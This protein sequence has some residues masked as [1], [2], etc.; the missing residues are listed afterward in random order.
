MKIK[1]LFLFFLLLYLAVIVKLFFAQVVSRNI[2]DLDLYLKTIQIT[3]E[4]GRIFDI[5]DNP[6][7]LNQNSYLL[8]LLP[9]KI[10]DKDYLAHLLSQKINI[11][12]ASLAADINENLF[13][14]AIKSGIGEKTKNEIEKLHLD[15]VGFNY[16]LKRY[17]PEASL[18]AHLVGF[19]GK[20]NQ[21]ADVGYFGLEG[22]YDKDLKGLPGFL[23]TERDVIGNPIFIGTQN[24]VEADNGR[25]LI[26]TLDKSV[27]EIA[28]NEL[29]DG[30][31]KYK[32][33]QGCV[34]VA[35]PNTMAITALTCLPDYD[36]DQYYKFTENY[37]E[38]PAI[39]SAY[40]PGS[41]FKPLIMSA[42]INEKKVTPIDTMT[43]AGPVKI[44][45]Y[46]IQTWDNTYEG[47]ISM[48][49]ILEKSS[50]V[51]M[52]YIGSKLGN[53]LLYKYLIKYGFNDYT[54]IDLQGETAGFIKPKSG[55]YPID[56]ATATFGQGIAVT[57]IQ[58]ITAFSSLINGGRLMRPYVVSKIISPG[59]E[60]VIKPKVIRQTISPLTSNIIKKMLVDT[61]EHGE[62][63]WQRPAGY[64]IGGK[65]GTA[66]IPIKGYYDPSKTIASFIGFAPADKPKFIVLVMLREPQTSIWGSETA[67]PMFF[68]IAKQLIVYYGIP[69]SQ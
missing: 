28:K 42:A 22:Y 8:Y 59:K 24:R 56:Y 26:L 23:E 37:F 52:V 65:T 5:N 50:N 66:Q 49:R 14:Q 19:V 25:D 61:V 3:P 20:D 16:Q 39:S 40:E 21:G 2:K 41:I 36:L 57:P 30:I 10:S 68:D 33:K 67:A 17:Y 32:A 18:S 15:S 35:D 53:D 13:Y 64:A 29:Q 44:G 27:Q 60:N 34:I 51:G 47:T 6:L 46:S 69:P 48:T 54:G 38:D 31:E 62:V 58:M 43:E 45:N 63:K 7:V 1:L 12:E 9:K 11:P 4:R 55:W